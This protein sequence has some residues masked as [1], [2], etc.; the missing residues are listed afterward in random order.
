MGLPPPSLSN[1]A[2]N[3]IGGGEGPKSHG[4]AEISGEQR[5]VGAQDSVSLGEGER[6]A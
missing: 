3:A 6:W 5:G 1:P 4:P 2:P